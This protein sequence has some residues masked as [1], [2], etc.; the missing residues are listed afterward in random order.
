MGFFEV[1]GIVFFIIL[2]MILIVVGGC[3][4]LKMM[5]FQNPFGRFNKDLKNGFTHLSENILRNGVVF[6]RDLKNKK[7]AFKTA[8]DAAI[9]AYNNTR[10]SSSSTPTGLTTP[11]PVTKGGK[12]KGG[13]DSCS[14]GGDPMNNSSLTYSLNN[15]LQ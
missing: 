12:M 1:L 15:F 3:F 13:C 8:K 11:E 2:I 4:I 10:S 9:N 5:G 6:Q 14:Y 7:D